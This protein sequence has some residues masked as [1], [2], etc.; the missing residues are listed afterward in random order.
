MRI[1]FN[2]PQRETTYQ[3]TLDVL[4]LSPC[5]LAFLITAEVPEI[6]MHQFWNTIKKIKDTDAYRFKLD[7]QKFRINT[8]VF[9]EILNIC[10]RLPNQDFVE[11]PFKEEMVPSVK[12]L[13]CM[14]GKSTDFMFQADNR[15]ISYARKENMPYLR[16]TKVIINHFMS[17]DKTIS[18]RI[19]INL[20][21]IRDDSLLETLKYVSK[22]KD[23]QEYGALIPEHMINQS[24]KDSKEYKI[25]LAYATGAATPKKAR[26]FKK[27]AS[28]LKKRTLVTKKALAKVARSKEIELL[29]DVALLEEAQLKKALKISKRETTIHQVGTGLKPRVLDVST[30]DSSVSKNESWGDSGY[31]ANEQGDDEDVLESDDDHEQADDERTKSDDEEEET[32]DDEY[33]HTPNDYVPTDDE[34]NDE[35]E[36]VTQ[37][38]YERIN[39]ELYG[40]IN[41]SLTDAEPTNKE[42]D[43][44]EMI[45][46]GHMNVNQEGTGNQVKDDA[47][48]TQKTEGR[49]P[50]SSI[51]FDYVAKYF[52]FDNIP[53]VDTEV[54]SMLDIDVQHEVFFGKSVNFR[55]PRTWINKIAQAEKPPLS[56]DELMSTPIDFSA[57]VMNYLKID[58]LTQEHL[59]GPA[60][61][62]LKGTL[63]NVIKL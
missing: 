57:H 48:A 39:E 31:E 5:Y 3:V 28:P 26:K 11:P 17:K 44:E 63:K 32:Q 62:L 8:D 12:E 9:C 36:D 6:Y 20:Y 37:E 38:E 18:I 60:F 24:I 23:Y 50:S 42:K 21:T 1:E 52:N 34:M 25:Y 46:V 35:S 53:P 15:D 45:V 33:V 56:F 22:I 4:K 7:K 2:K 61:N 49:I 10:P 14:F 19:R 13:G 58:N 43:A 27:P 54:V 29:S 40:D 30:A 41:V 47:Q 59:V 55:P 16:F 51:S